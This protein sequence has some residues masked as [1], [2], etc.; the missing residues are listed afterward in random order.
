MPTFDFTSP[1]GKSYSVDGPEGA[2]SEQAFKMLQQHL[3]TGDSAQSSE[4]SSV[5]GAAKSLGV[6]AAKG[7]LGLAGLPGDVYHAGLRAL[8]DNLTPESNY[9]SAALQKGIEGYTG[10]FYKPKGGIEETAQKVGE[11]LPAVLGGPETLGAKVLTRAVAPAVASEAAGKLTE[12]TAAQPYA[13]LAGALAGGVGGTMAA[14]KFKQMAAARQAASTVPSG[15]DLLRSG[16]NGF[17]AV[18]ASNAVIKPSSVEQIA[19]DVRTE[20]LNDGKHPSIGSQGGV[21]STLDRLENLGAQGGG[22][23]PKDL[24]VI[25][26]NLVGEKTNLDPGTAAA[27]R[28]ATDS[29]MKKYSSL[30]QQ[31]LLNGSNPFPTL[32]DAVGD[33]A[34]GKRS[35]TIQGKVNLAELNAGTAGS[36]AN[37]DN[38]MR[39]A[40]KQLA[41]PMNNTNTP[42]WKK[43]GFSNQEGAAIEQAATGTMV[44]NAARYLGKAAPTGIVSAT[45]SG[46]AG[47]MVGGPVGAVALPIAGYIAKKI[48]DLST[49]RA[50][51]AVDSLVRSRSPLAA[52]VAQHLPPQL[53]SM[54]PSKS[55][56]TLTALIAADRLL[57]R[58]NA[59]AVPQ[60]IDASG[61]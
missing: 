26:K 6:G 48:G 28:Q 5:S 12:G 30:G 37:I 56:R 57:A 41:R 34:A 39:Q 49:K 46:G 29:F 21:F 22:V 43:L 54:L 7:V 18:K 44:G 8:G 53:I 47:H 1:D 51:N 59:S 11:F 20:L 3:G 24:E 15:E 38:N 50:V 10:D 16:S 32:K 14:N 9:G 42:I 36:G 55:A 52:Q 45:M 23:T 61:N 27:A 31:D 25:R 2:T 17:E 35:Q 58:Q 33:W 13:E 19:K 4:G 60:Q 40:F